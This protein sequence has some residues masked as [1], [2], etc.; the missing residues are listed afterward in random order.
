MK[1]GIAAWYGGVEYIPSENEDIKIEIRHSNY[2]DWDLVKVEESANRY[3][4]QSTL[5][6]DISEMD[7]YRA[8]LNDIKD[9]KIVD[10]EKAKVVVYTTEENLEKLRTNLQNYYKQQ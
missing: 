9:L 2:V 3:A 1:G 5:K 10:Y 7:M 6:D 4:I 8:V